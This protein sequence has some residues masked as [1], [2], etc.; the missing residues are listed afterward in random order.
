LPPSNEFTTTTKEVSRQAAFGE[1]K[2]LFSNTIFQQIIISFFFR[3]VRPLF[4]RTRRL[5]HV[6]RGTRP[7]NRTQLRWMQVCVR[8]E[9]RTVGVYEWCLFH[10]KQ[11]TLI[12]LP[13][14][15]SNAVRR[16]IDRAHA[17]AWCR[18][19]IDTHYRRRSFPS[20]RLSNNDILDWIASVCLCDCANWH[21]A[22]GSTFN[23]HYVYMNCPKKLLVDVDS[24]TTPAKSSDI[25]NT[26]QI[27]QATA[28]RVLF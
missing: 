10:S 22:S 6:R 3:H 16:S 23:K 28:A 20:T 24:P 9:Q 4:W 12:H 15:H 1:L 18:R 17:T 27:Q 21:N 2:W 14:S 19:K 8:D 25:Q 13:A 11:L 26:T 7:T 5:Y